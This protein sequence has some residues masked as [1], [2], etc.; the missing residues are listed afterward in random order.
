MINEKWVKLRQLGKQKYAMLYGSLFW[1]SICGTSSIVPLILL[2]KVNSIVLVFIHYLVWM[3]GGYF[4]GCY[5]WE[6]QEK[7]VKSEFL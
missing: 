5:N 1:G 3:I 2:N 6:K 4:F 7:L